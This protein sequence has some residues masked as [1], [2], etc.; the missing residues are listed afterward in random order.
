[1]AVPQELDGAARQASDEDGVAVYRFRLTLQGT[2]DA[3][4][5]GTIKSAT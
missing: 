1:M 2:D 5:G 3:G 4:K